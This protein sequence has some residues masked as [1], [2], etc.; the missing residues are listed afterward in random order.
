[1]RVTLQNPNYY[2]VTYRH[3]PDADGVRTFDPTDRATDVLD[4]LRR[5]GQ[6]DPKAVRDDA[7]TRGAAVRVPAGGAT[8][9]ATLTGPGTVTELRLRLPDVVGSGVADYGGT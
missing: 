1:M 5:A 8:D 4:M 9:V 6:R 2:H 3:F 7:T